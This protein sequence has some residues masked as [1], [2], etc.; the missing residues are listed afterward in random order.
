MTDVMSNERSNMQ[1]TYMNDHLASLLGYDANPSLHQ[2]ATDDVDVQCDR[3]WWRKARKLESQNVSAEAELD[4]ASFP[5]RNSLRGE[6][7]RDFWEEDDNI[8]NKNNHLLPSSCRSHSSALFTLEEDRQ[9]WQ[10]LCKELPYDTPMAE[11]LALLSQSN[12]NRRGNPRSDDPE[13]M[14]RMKMKMSMDA[15]LAAA[16]HHVPKRQ[17]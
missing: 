9:E 4:A 2:M 15:P 6:I 10:R 16:C 11:R 5:A 12:C 3:D 13:L 1:V 17:S 7:D 8:D 14:S